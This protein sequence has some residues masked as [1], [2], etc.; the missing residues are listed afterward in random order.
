MATWEPKM[1][2]PQKYLTNLLL[3]LQVAASLSAWDATAGA[4]L[5]HNLSTDTT[6]DHGRREVFASIVKSLNMAA[7]QVDKFGALDAALRN[8]LREQFGVATC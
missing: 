8:A 7:G 1:T 3:V 2:D 4:E 6:I 5:E